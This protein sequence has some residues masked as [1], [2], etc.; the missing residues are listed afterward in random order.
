MNPEAVNQ[1]VAMMVQDERPLS[2]EL[3]QCDRTIL[4]RMRKVRANLLKVRL[5]T[6][7]VTQPPG[8]R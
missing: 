2:D 1:V 5:V 3:N 6:W 8:F 4:E 7:R